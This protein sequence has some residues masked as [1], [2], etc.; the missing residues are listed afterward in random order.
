M[1]IYG[2]QEL[3]WQEAQQLRDRLLV[4]LGTGDGMKIRNTETDVNET[5]KVGLLGVQPERRS[6]K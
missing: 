3:D 2:K 4:K 1:L 5:N 6:V